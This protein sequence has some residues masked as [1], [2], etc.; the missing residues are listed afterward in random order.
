MSKFITSSLKDALNNP[1]GKLPV[2]LRCKHKCNIVEDKLEHEFGFTPFIESD[3][4][5]APVTFVEEKNY[6]KPTQ[7][8]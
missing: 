6:V 4:C 3:C 5:G 2:C 7:T 1:P 8:D